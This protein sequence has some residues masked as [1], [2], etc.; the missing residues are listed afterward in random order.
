M[1]M[2]YVIKLKDG[3]YSHEQPE[4][5]WSVTEDIVDAAVFHGTVAVETVIKDGLEN[6]QIF[7]IGGYEILEVKTTVDVVRAHEI[8]TAD[9]I[10]F[11]NTHAHL[12]DAM[13]RIDP[14][15]LA[16]AV[17]LINERTK[18]TKERFKELA[19]VPPSKLTRQFNR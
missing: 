4:F 7:L 16:K 8:K 3:Y 10:R 6:R 11:M 15:D 13:R 17:S 1:I 14:A 2:K 12:L 9:D 5:S 19:S 18:V